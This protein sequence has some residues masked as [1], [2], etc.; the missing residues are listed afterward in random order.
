MKPDK[1]ISVDIVYILSEKSLLNCVKS[2]I[3]R[4]KMEWNRIDYLSTYCILVFFLKLCV[5]V[6]LQVTSP[7]TNDPEQ[8]TPNSLRL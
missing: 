7:P 1:V 8:Q 4:N 3:L 5:T 2:V 6:I